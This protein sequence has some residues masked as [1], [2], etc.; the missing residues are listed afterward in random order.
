MILIKGALG[1]KWQNAAERGHTSDRWIATWKRP[2]HR[3]AHFGAGWGGV[4][5]TEAEAQAAA[6]EEWGA[7]RGTPTSQEEAQCNLSGGQAGS[8]V[9]K[10]K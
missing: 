2:K 5:W 3:A 8:N 7:A 4:G 9:Y 1:N 10:C 6:A